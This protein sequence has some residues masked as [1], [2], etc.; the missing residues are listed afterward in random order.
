M[1]EIC[2]AEI[3]ICHVIKQNNV[4]VVHFLESL[5]ICSSAFYCVSFLFCV[6]FIDYKVTCFNGKRGSI[7]N[8]FTVPLAPGIVAMWQVN[9][10]GRSL[11]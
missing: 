4:Q 6:K 8:P 2:C 7:F 9:I 11:S 10:V 3:L 1:A 5:K